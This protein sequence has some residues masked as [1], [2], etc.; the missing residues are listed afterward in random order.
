MF[1]LFPC[2]LGLL[3]LTACSNSEKVFKPKSEQV[4]NST[5]EYKRNK[6]VVVISEKS[7]ENNESKESKEEKIL[8]KVDVHRR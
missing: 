7:K 3:I 4:S 5:D 1:N 2:F 6:E 8:I